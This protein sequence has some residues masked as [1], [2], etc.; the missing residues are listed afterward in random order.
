MKSTALLASGLGL[1]ISLGGCGYE[2]PEIMTNQNVL[3]V[4]VTSPHT[5]TYPA[6]F[7]S[8]HVSGKL[9]VKQCVDFATEQDCTNFSFRIDDYSKYEELNNQVGELLPFESLGVSD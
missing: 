2:S 9:T 8:R 4:G 5:E 1:T 6:T 3:I 7:S